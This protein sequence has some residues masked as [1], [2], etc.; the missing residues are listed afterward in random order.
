MGIKEILFWNIIIF[1]FDF[2]DVDKLLASALPA[3]MGRKRRHQAANS[4][5]FPNKR[6]WLHQALSSTGRSKADIQMHSELPFSRTVI[7]PIPRL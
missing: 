2:I 6:Q 3:A 1:S 7:Q 5:R 4:I